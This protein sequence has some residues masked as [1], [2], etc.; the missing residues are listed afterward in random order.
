MLDI[1]YRVIWKCWASVFIYVPL[2]INLCDNT[3]VITRTG[4]NNDLLFRNLEK[5]FKEILEKVF[6]ESSMI[7]FHKWIQTFF[8]YFSKKRF[9]NF[10][11]EFFFYFTIFFERMIPYFLSMFLLL[12]KR[13]PFHIGTGTFISFVAML[14]LK[15]YLSVW[16]FVWAT[17][18]LKNDQF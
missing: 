12:L 9:P 6:K 4:F 13:S 5:V 2:S 8:K 11:Q 17:N 16:I 7:F 18:H 3:N 1:F 10:I 14:Q 15:V